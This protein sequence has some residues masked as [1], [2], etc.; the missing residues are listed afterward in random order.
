MRKL[1]SALSLLGCVAFVYADDAWLGLYRQGN[2]I[3]YAHSAMTDTLLNKVPAKK[4]ESSTVM[5]AGLL[6]QAM[7]IT[8][9][10]TSW[11][12]LK[13]RPILM[14]FKVSS[15]GRIQTLDALFTLT[16]IHLNVDN[17]GAK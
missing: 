15:A 7:S 3:G 10:S 2:K 14:K 13:G 11:L 1:L 8:I 6:G 17:S 4:S 5:N 9:N 12:D 16:E